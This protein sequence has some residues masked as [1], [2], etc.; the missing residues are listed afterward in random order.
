MT[1]FQSRGPSIK[2]WRLLHH[3]KHKTLSHLT[4]TLIEKKIKRKKLFAPLPKKSHK[5]RHPNPRSTPDCDGENGDSTTR[6]G[7]TGPAGMWHVRMCTGALLW[8]LA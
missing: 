5:T 4:F 6:Y 2:R 3:L 1:P 7:R 8:R